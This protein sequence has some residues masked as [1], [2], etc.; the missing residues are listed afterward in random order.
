MQ[1]ILQRFSLA[2]D[3]P[4]AE[5]KKIKHVKSVQEYNDEYDKL[6]CRVELSEK[7][8]IIFFLVGLPNDVEVAIMMFK[9][10]SLAELYG[11]AKFPK[12]VSLP[13][14]NSNWKNRIANPN[15][16][17]IRK[18]LT[19]KELEE[20]RAKNLCFYCDKKYAP[21]HKC[22]SQMFSLE[23]VVNDEEDIMWGATKEDADCEL[24]DV[25]NIV[26][27]ED[28]VPHM[29][30]NALTDYNDVF[31]IPKEFL[32]VKSHDHIIPLKEG[33]PTANIRPYRHPATQKDFIENGSWRMRVDYR[34][35]NKHTIKDKFQVHLIEELI[36]ELC[37]SKA[38]SMLD[39]RS[40]YHQIR[41][42][43]DDIAKTAF[44]THQGHYEFLVMPFDLT[45]TSLTF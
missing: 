34:Q 20:K 30:L 19:Q 23:V 10:R 37:G 21:S 44:Q 18:Q 4:L 22:H 9:P 33:S 43:L 26:H 31:A 24:F 28:S 17:P 27:E 29:S 8:S 25:L 14:S 45:N 2:Y 32:P 41:M 7:Q 36:D 35:L 6:L 16:A 15:T 11:L 39:L 42:Y 5:I 3:D 13:T 38:F 1:A 40:G 12:P